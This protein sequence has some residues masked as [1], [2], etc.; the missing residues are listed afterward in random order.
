[1]RRRNCTISSTAFAYLAARHCFAL[2]L[3]N[4]PIYD[5]R[6]QIFRS[7][8]KHTPRGLSDI[9]AIKDGRVYFLE[10]KGEKGRPSQDQLDFGRRVILAGAA[11]HVVRSID[12]VQTLG[13]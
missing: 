5:A 2:R 8:P 12:E 11:Y 7:L 6:R 13:L 10:V 9:L 4:Q 1:M 3:N